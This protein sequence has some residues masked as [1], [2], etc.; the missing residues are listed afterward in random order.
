MLI[1]NSSS[2]RLLGRK[3]STRQ[4]VTAALLVC[5][6]LLLVGLTAKATRDGFFGLILVPSLQENVH[7]PFNYLRG[8]STSVEK[9]RIDIKHQDFLKIAGKRAEA[10]EIGQL[11]Y[12]PDEDWVP[13]ILTHRG[14]H[15][16]A[17]IRLK[18]KLADHWA[19]DHWSFKVAIKGGD[20]LLGMRR[21]A[22][23]HPWTRDYLSEWYF[24]QLLRHAGLIGL[25]Y[26]FVELT[27]NGKTMP[28][29]ALEENFDK[30][31]IENNELREGPIFKLASRLNAERPRVEAFFPYQERSYNESPESL[32]I[33]RRAERR[34][35]YLGGGLDASQVFDLAKGAT[36]YAL[37]DL[38]GNKH[39]LGTRNSRFYMNP[40][41]GLI[42]PIAYDS[43]VFNLVR[44]EGLVIERDL[45]RLTL[46]KDPAFLREY[47]GALERVSEP[48][49]LD[50]FL[51]RIE[52]EEKNKLAILHRS[53]PYYQPNDLTTLEVNQRYIR[54]FVN[55]K[56]NLQVFLKRWPDHERSEISLEVANLHAL[57]V[58]LVALRAGS[59]EIVL[60]DDVIIAQ[61]PPATNPN[62]RQEALQFHGITIKVPSGSVDDWGND[63]TLVS[64]HIGGAIK[65]ID[66]IYPWHRDDDQIEQTDRD[67]IA[68]L[69]FD[70]AT[71]DIHV[72][73][74]QWIVEDDLVIPRGHTLIAD[75][76]PTIELAPGVAIVSYSRL[77]FVGTAQN[78]IIVRSASEG[79][80][81]LAVIAARGLS[82][83]KHVIFENLGPIEKAG[84]SLPG[85][86]TFYES[87]VDIV[88]TR[89]RDMRAE[90]ALN[91]VRSR[92]S[93]E[94][95]HFEHTAAD[96]FDADFS[97][98]VVRRSRFSDIG[99]DAIDVSGGTVTLSQLELDNIGDKGISA[100]EATTVTAEDIR[101]TNASIALASK[102][103]SVVT[104]TSAKI[105]GGNIGIAVLQ[106][107]SEFGPS[108]VK[109]VNVRFEAVDEP[110]LLEP[111]SELSVDGRII[112]EHQSDVYDRIYSE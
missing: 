57:P 111:G 86:V 42:E 48:R 95:S 43:S 40:V 102:D 65:A 46:L 7:A 105:V 47:A 112:E 59:G 13:A 6:S 55:P 17:K 52:K 79:G 101:I 3:I 51:A 18:G 35:A 106:K 36:L 44:D 22:L 72:P 91:V 74:R 92:F 32:A 31:L 62:G 90:D 37:A 41:T 110:Y 63:T 89:F 100:G 96:A 99:N 25:R 27:I 76:G 21:F 50:D 68:F 87:D 1:K 49:F 98:G 58:E 30:R 2:T 71:N 69:Q 88:H 24:H 15:M 8:L 34:A 60:L 39:M 19:G 10:L 94:E 5:Y 107:K 75:P 93:I 67:A 70:E 38:V 73:A 29:Y 16:K 82:T 26:E 20:T 53:Y 81:G 56:K 108:T 109:V 14:K 9:I 64:R 12:D 54:E 4:I 33:L 23:Q 97:T 78:P 84:V 61:R 83:L 80:Q 45:P 77:A 11:Y 103:R 85:A 104:L 28:I 66:P